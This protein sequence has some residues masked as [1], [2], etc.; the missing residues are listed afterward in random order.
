MKVVMVFGAFDGI[1]PGHLDFFRQAKEHGESLVVSVGL[2]KNV[3]KIKGKKPLFNQDERLDLVRQL[4]IVDNA[5]LGAV[6]DFFQH[7]KQYSPDVICLGYDQWASDT[8][9]KREL[10]KVGLTKTEVVRLMPFDPA[11]AKSSIM[12]QKSAE[13]KHFAD[14]K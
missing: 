9:V 14:D 3:E 11:R 2:D 7:V 8:M 1:H 4:K 5:I 12:K 13:F 6:D 10:G